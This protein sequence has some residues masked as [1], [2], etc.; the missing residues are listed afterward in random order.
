LNTWR[1]ASQTM[2]RQLDSAIAWFR[3]VAIMFA[4]ADHSV[5]FE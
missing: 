5:R 4:L 2:S 3:R 1:I